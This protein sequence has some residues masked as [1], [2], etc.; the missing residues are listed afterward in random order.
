MHW[1]YM[2]GTN[3]MDLSPEVIEKVQDAQKALGK[4]E[5][6]PRAGEAFIIFAQAAM[7]TGHYLYGESLQRQF[8]TVSQEDLSKLV[9]A[10][11]AIVEL[12][13]QFLEGFKW[14]E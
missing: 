11:E 3:L 5:L 4:Y 8:P 12:R 9:E 10:F 13:N 6:L 1:P 7:V 2:K 14:K